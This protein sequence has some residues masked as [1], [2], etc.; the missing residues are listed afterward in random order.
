V[1]ILNS[2]LE[3][4]KDDAL[5]IHGNYYT[6][7]S[8]EA[9]V[10][11][12]RINT[13][14]QAN[15]GVNAHFQMFGAGDKIAIYEGGSMIRKGTLTVGR[16]CVTGDFTADIY[17]VG[18]ASSAAYGDTVENLSA[19]AELY[20]RNC[21]MGK[22]LTHLRLQTRG[23]VLIED[24]EC[25]LK[26]LLSGDKNYWYEGSPINDLTVRNCRFLTEHARIVACPEFDARAEAPYYHSGVKIIGNVFET[27]TA[28]ELSH[29]RDVVFCGN[30]NADG[31][32][33]C[34]VFCDCENV[35]EK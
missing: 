1:E 3:G 23:K 7:Q 26:V 28:L 25:S 15:P 17:V 35:S 8:V 19:Q 24:C 32:G 34:N 21:R 29:T 20:V 13:D 4:M 27:V 30:V 18:D 12:A 16:V 5:N 2:V 14:I 6:V 33:F 22:A 10:L 31:N 9:G 11:H